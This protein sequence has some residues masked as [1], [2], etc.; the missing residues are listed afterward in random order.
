MMS[1]KQING[2]QVL[3]LKFS[4]NV[5]SS[6]YI[7]FKE[8]AVREQK[9]DKPSGRTL[10]VLNIPPYATEESIK[11]AFKEAGEIVSVK[12]SKKPSSTEIEDNNIDSYFSSNI[13]NCFKIGYLVF[14]KVSDLDRA[15]KLTS[16][17]TLCSEENDLKCGLS[18]WV[19]EYNNSVPIIPKLKKEIDNF[20]MAY[21]KKKA[22]ES[23]T[24]KALE[25]EDEEGWITVTKKSKVQSFS[26]TEN[27]VNKV[28]EKEKVGKQR[29]ELQNFY[30]FQIR[31]SKMKHIVAL[32]QRFEDDKK[33]INQ[34]KQSRRFKPF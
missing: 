21:D 25:E 3:P 9:E 18:K 14:S 26:R 28:M 8:H 7:Y 1:P 13:S 32:R 19:Q 2:F 5:K 10:F 12:F 17:N 16:L 20:M 33:K 31:E 11:H 23:K 4:S 29:K 22:L 34:L 24:V 15:M 27:V 6:H 30:T